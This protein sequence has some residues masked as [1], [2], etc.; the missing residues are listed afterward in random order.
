MFY[1]VSAGRQK[2][3]HLTV[4]QHLARCEEALEDPRNEEITLTQAEWDALKT[5]LI[6]NVEML[7]ELKK[8]VDNIEQ[9]E[10]TGVVKGYDKLLKKLKRLVR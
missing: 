5:V 9:K 2:C 1:R 10:I 8:R 7:E 3:P 4:D 6:T